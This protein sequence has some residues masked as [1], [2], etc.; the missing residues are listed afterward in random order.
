[1]QPEMQPEMQPAFEFPA[2]Y[3]KSH[4]LPLLDFITVAADA[5]LYQQ[6]EYNSWQ[7]HLIQ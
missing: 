2:T 7:Y 6:K 3:K 1:M 5:H 4:Q